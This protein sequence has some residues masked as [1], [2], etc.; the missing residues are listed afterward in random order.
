[1]HTYYYNI[2]TVIVFYGTPEKLHVRY[3]WIRSFK[4]LQQ[5]SSDTPTYYRVPLNA[6]QCLCYCIIHICTLNIESYAHNFIH[7]VDGTLKG[8]SLC[9]TTKGF[10]VW[11][12]RGASNKECKIPNR[13]QSLLGPYTAPGYPHTSSCC[14]EGAGNLRTLWSSVA[15]VT[16]N[17]LHN[18]SY[19]GYTGIIY[20]KKQYNASYIRTLTSSYI[21]HQEWHRTDVHKTCLFSRWGH[22]FGKFLFQDCHL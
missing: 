15:R 5:A 16:E 2:C 14:R 4:W 21:G 20:S 10:I 11:C 17:A 18:W 13:H 9:S 8:I 3:S 6:K 12:C 19:Q 1:M 7:T 22:R